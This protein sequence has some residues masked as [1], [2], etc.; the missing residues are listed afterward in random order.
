MAC[1]SDV[2]LDF[3][4]IQVGDTRSIVREISEQDVRRFVEMTG[5]DNPLHVDQEFAAST[6]FKEPR[7]C[8]PSSARGCQGLVHCGFRKP[9]IFFTRCAWATV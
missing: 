6:C 8:R 3:A 1:G 2:Y 9:W 4:D 5:D 7:S